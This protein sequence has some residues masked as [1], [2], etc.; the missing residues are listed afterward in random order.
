M[1]SFRQAMAAAG[2]RFAGDLEADGKLR[3]VHVEGDRKGSR[4]GWYVL[5]GDGVPAGAF[6]TN[7]GDLRFKWRA[8]DGANRWSPEE[9]TRQREEV[10]RKT[11]EQKAAESALQADAAARA[12]AMWA[13]AADATDH[14]YLARKRVPG[15]GLR[16]GVWVKESPPD[17]V[18]GEIRITRTQN[19]L[20][21]P[22]R[23]AK[24][25]IVSLQA[26][27]AS[28][29]AGR[30]K[31]FV[32]GGRKRGCWF[33]IGKPTEVD[34]VQTIVICEGYA[35]GASIH[36]ATGLGV[37]VAFDAGNLQPVA[38]TVHR[39]MPKA[40]ILIAGDNDAF[41]TNAKGEPWNPGAEKAQMAA[42]GLDCDWVV[43]IFSSD[44]DQ[45]TDFNDLET[46]E[47]ENAVREQ[48]M[49]A[50]RAPAER[51]PEP[52]IRPD[53][54]TAI[55]QDFP[56]VEVGPMP[57]RDDT[58][59]GIDASDFFTV[60][61]HDRD[62]IYVYQHKAQMI[63][64]RGF[65]DWPEAALTWLAPLDWWEF[66]FPGAKGF[67]RKMAIAWL[68]DQAQRAGV[69]D[70]SRCRGRGAW[71]DEDRIVYHCGDHLIVD[72]RKTPIASFRSNY[73][74]EQGQK[75]KP[76]A[77]QP[78]TAADGERIIEVAQLF[79]WTRPGSAI[80][81]AGFVALA[82]LCGAFRWRPHTWITGG[83]GSGKSTILNEF[84]WPLMGGTEVYAQG[85][86]TEAGI[87]QS[88]GTDARPVLFD[89]SEQNNEREENRIQGV[90]ALVRQ[91]STESGARTL[92]GTPGG[93]VM[94]F[95]VRSMFCL[96][97]IQVGMKHQADMERIT[98]LALRPKKQDAHD[99]AQAVQEWKRLSGALCELKRDRELPS[100]LL[101]R[102]LELLPITLQNI[103][104]F[105]Q[106][107]AE[108]FGSQR[109]GDQFGAMLAGAWSLVSNEHA[110]LDEARAMIERYDWSEYTED[111]ETEE[112]DKALWTLMESK[113]RV[114][115]GAEVSVYEVVAAAA[116]QA[117]ESYDPGEKQADA[118][119]RRHGMAIKWAGPDP[120]NAALLIAH[121]SKEL[122]RLLKDTPYAA[123]I[124]GQFG[125][126]SGATPH[127]GTSFCGNRSRA[128]GI[129]LTEIID[130]LAGTGEPR[131]CQVD[132][133]IPF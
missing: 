122:K 73:I 23:D 87:R 2:V 30:D 38:E 92:K 14:P 116:R 94:G 82:P 133:D 119:L 5:H 64:V 71:M 57:R 72:G 58:S 9:R 102:S 41:T 77:E 16:V 126:V 80:L 22:I 84:I 31:D 42:L 12:Q 129:P 118:I 99:G 91:S 50:L 125:R 54:E 33:T 85:N 10:V 55:E 21:I 132:E 61:G 124:K 32:F 70:P 78:M 89:E 107:A 49:A 83:A 123:D 131:A 40:R 4:N 6:G 37:V 34:G 68:Q 106:A 39:I 121:H 97:S 98:V 90:L 25:N 103:E 117:L 93:L 75:L 65:S 51:A 52:D 44:A 59:Y 120:H 101:K 1:D 35:T 81:V 13:D 67:S 88:L 95:L 114:N 104:I 113:L 69:F 24:K 11:T 17:P 79:R 109:E 127:K 3:R 20:L 56:P 100:R 62:S 28:K 66:N 63:C 36:R 18:T 130:D 53:R 7:K 47:G 74:Y 112:S 115:H 128:V 111:S 8:A 43:P 27:F 46:E 86:S 108:K 105:S 29:V 15:Y 26:V 96:A 60:R 110:T 19:A 76:P 48:I 45:P